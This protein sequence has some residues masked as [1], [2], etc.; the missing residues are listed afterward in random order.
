[1]GY[2]F[3]PGHR[4]RLSLSTSYWPIMLPPPHDAGLTIDTGS[5]ELSLPKLGDAERIEMKEPENP[6]P[7]PSYIEQLPPATRRNVTRELSTGTTIYRIHEDTGRH[8]HPGTGLATRQIR[9]EEWSIREGDP[10]SMSGE[11]S[12][13]CDMFRD[14]W[15]VRTISNARMTCTATDWV[16]SAEVKAFDGDEQIFEKMFEKVVPRDMM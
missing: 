9:E 11:A 16:I 4:I 7:L 6:S 10:L 2:R 13:V 8:E 3:A 15:S 14:G 5:I 1:M 12:W